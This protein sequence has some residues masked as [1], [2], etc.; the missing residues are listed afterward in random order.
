MSQLIEGNSLDVLKEFP[1]NYF[2]SCIT[3]PPY[4]L[5]FMGN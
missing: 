4:E 2:S 5:G 3:D 1:D